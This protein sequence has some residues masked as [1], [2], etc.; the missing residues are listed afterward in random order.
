M[1]HS[2]GPLVIAM[3]VAKIIPYISAPIETIPED[4]ANRMNHLRGNHPLGKALF[5][6]LLVRICA[7]YSDTSNLQQ[8][9]ISKCIEQIKSYDDAPKITDIKWFNIVLHWNGTYF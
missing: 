6:Q 4:M 9:Q 2:C 1:H 3:A 7:C 8:L 5:Q